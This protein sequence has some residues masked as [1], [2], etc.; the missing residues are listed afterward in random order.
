MFKE[1]EANLYC[2]QNLIHLDSRFKYKN[3]IIKVLGE[4]VWKIFTKVG[5][6]K[7]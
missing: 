3:E 5:V 4:N 7:D 6:E 2:E 1:I